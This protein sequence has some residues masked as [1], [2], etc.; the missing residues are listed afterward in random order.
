MKSSLLPVAA[1]RS[2]VISSYHGVDVSEDY[3]WLEDP[4]DRQVVEWTAAQNRRTRDF[5]DQLAFRPVLEARVRQ[6]LDSGGVSYRSVCRGG[7]TYFALK[8]QPPE[9]QPFIVALSDL[10][11]TASERVVVDPN[12]IDPSGQ[13]AIGLF[14]PSPDGAQLAV[15]LAEHGSEDG[16]IYVYDVATGEVVDTPIAHAN[17]A[18]AVASLAWRHDGT[19]FWYSRADEAGFHQQVWIHEL[20]AGNDAPELG[21]TVFADPVVVENFL[22]VSGDGHWVMDRAQKGDGGEWQ[23]FVRRQPSAS[24]APD[25]MA[26]AGWWQVAGIADRCVEA[27]FGPGALFLLS[28]ADSAKGSILRMQLAPGA[29]VGADAEQVVAPDERAITGLAV[30]DNSLWV[31]DIDGGPCG[32]RVY[33][34]DGSP[35]SEIEVPP[36]SAV[37]GLTRSAPDEVVW[38]VESFTT[39]AT[40]WVGADGGRDIE[41]SRTGLATATSIDLSGYEVTREF[42]SSKDGTRVPI[43]VVA[44]PGTPRDGSA[45]ALL[46]AYGGYGISLSPSFDASRLVWL[47]QGGVY[48][49]ANIRGGGEYGEQWHEQG[50]LASKQNCFDDFIA[51]AD[52]LVQT[53]I[54]SRERLAIRG[55]SNGGL[56]MGAVLTQRPDL[57]RAVVAEVPVM[58]MLRAETTPNGRYNVTEYGTVEDPEMFAVLRAYSPY[59]NVVD[60]TPYPA[61]LLTGGE[62]DP[63]VDAWHPKKMAARLQAATGSDEPVL[64]RIEAGGHGIGQSLAQLA[65]LLT[66]WYAFLFDRL[67]IEYPLGDLP[68]RG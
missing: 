67:G 37:S 7:S 63:R 53:G 55:G 36:V 17:P 45:P 43:S 57:A 21:G 41:T 33:G 46:T 20:G 6:L 28:Y 38:A 65:T 62:F 12:L 25:Q 61:V 47:E 58:D 31:T 48:A 13:T 35:R 16:T 22:T 4:A 44:A 32:L 8:R 27:V 29:T 42:A 2:T 68:S 10:S 30:T 54:T 60:G 66:D 3:R 18:A 34:L 14:V 19:G 59:H 15:S 49:V 5:L 9:Q 51:C 11:D 64:L 50:R 40:W 23:I 26:D 56:L 1:A 24:E 52:H 39:P